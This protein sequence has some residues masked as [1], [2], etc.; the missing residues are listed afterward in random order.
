MATSSL[1]DYHQEQ[2]IQ[3]VLRDITMEKQQRY[4]SGI[5][6]AA[7]QYSHDAI[8]VTDPQGGI[9]LVNKAFH[10]LTGYSPREAIGRS[11]SILNSGQHDSAFFF[12]MWKALNE[13]GEWT[14]DIVNRKRHGELYIQETLITTVK[15]CEG[16]IRHFVCLMRDVTEKRSGFDYRHLKALKKRLEEMYSDTQTPS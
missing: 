5:A 14:G 3:V 16:R 8:M 11:A 15:D 2:V 9:E 7:F 13:A 1:I 10:Q 6:Q 4:L 12:R